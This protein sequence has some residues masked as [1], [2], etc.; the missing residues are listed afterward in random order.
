MNIKALMFS[1]SSSKGYRFE[2]EG[3][4]RNLTFKVLSEVVLPFFIYSFIR[5]S[6]LIIY[7]ALEGNIT[8]ETFPVPTLLECGQR[9][10]RQLPKC[11]SFNYRS[12]G[13][14]AEK[15]CD[16]NNATKRDAVE[17]RFSEDSQS[18]YGEV[19]TPDIKVKFVLSL[20]ARA[21]IRS[22]K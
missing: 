19:F 21:S 1:R 5:I 6:V 9:C 22:K 17:A 11:K 7:T 20:N 15:L 18:V 4:V 14:F 16:I 12:V 10:M 2:F 13:S 3:K 8:F